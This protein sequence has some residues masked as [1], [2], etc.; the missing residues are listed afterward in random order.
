[1]R[2]LSLTIAVALSVVLAGARATETSASETL[3][4][5]QQLVEETLQNRPTLPA[6]A[7]AFTDRSDKFWRDHL[8]D[9]LAE[10]ALYQSLLSNYYRT[11][12]LYH[13]DVT[14]DV[15]RYAANIEGFRP[16]DSHNMTPEDAILSVGSASIALWK[17]SEAFTSLPVINRVIGGSAL[18]EVNYCYNDA[19]AK[20]KPGE[21]VIYCDNDIYRGGKPN[22]VLERFKE[23]SDRMARDLPSSKVMFLSIKPTPSDALAGKGIRRNA[24]VTNGLIRE[25]IATRK[26]MQFVDVAPPRLWNGEQ[27]RQ[28]FLPDGMHLNAMLP[29]LEFPGYHA[30]G[31]SLR[32]IHGRARLEEKCG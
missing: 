22:T 19:I 5:Y 28:L 25:F 20:Y 12:N 2:R 32:A 29:A 16:W 30:P 17:T 1:M 10:P 27:H 18:L 11:E 24:V 6:D 4:Q 9:Y 31:E 21:V 23:L 14:P 7:Q 26:N 13:R 15:D 3:Q 8:K